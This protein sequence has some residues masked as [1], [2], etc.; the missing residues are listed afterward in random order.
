MIW[1]PPTSEP[2]DCETVA[3]WIEE[4]AAELEREEHQKRT[5]RRVAQPQRM[6]KTTVAA[7]RQ[8]A[9]LDMF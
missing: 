2:V 4:I 1:A 3:S 5:I 7:I 9:E 6:I 8:T